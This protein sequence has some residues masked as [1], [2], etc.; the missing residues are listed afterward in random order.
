M[1]DGRRGRSTPVAFPSGSTALV[2]I[3]A[4]TGR[5]VRAPGHRDYWPGVPALVQL[6][7]GDLPVWLSPRRPVR[8]S[9]GSS[10]RARC[11][12][13]PWLAARSPCRRSR[14][15]RAGGRRG[16]SEGG[17]GGDGDDPGDCDELAGLAHEAWAPGGLGSGPRV[18][19]EPSTT[20]PTENPRPSSGNRAARGFSC[21]EGAHA[22]NG[23]R[24]TR[25]GTGELPARTWS[26]ASSGRPSA[27]APETVLQLRP[28]ARCRWLRRGPRPLV[29]GREGLRLLILYRIGRL[30]PV[31]LL[32][33]HG[34]HRWPRPSP[35]RSARLR[36]GARRSTSRARGRTGRRTG[37]RPLLHQRLVRGVETC[38]K[39][40]AFGF[41]LP[42]LAAA[43]GCFGVVSAP[44]AG[45]GVGLGSSLIVTSFGGTRAG[46]S[47]PPQISIVGRFPLC[48]GLSPGHTTTRLGAEASAGMWRALPPGVANPFG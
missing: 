12:G 13:C 40:I 31:R 32:L 45:S 23:R 5:P 48:A 3:P 11:P 47:K 9:T 25:S 38:T 7:A 4:S 43:P 39:L 20:S 37:R 19:G 30:A 35:G 10:G 41:D 29:N 46:F 1:P 36:H 26:T 33:E 6:P 21:A 24:A 14:R 2:C 27:S 16:P 42:Q 44:L 17:A 34:V 18:V 15:V 28:E 8:P 22:A